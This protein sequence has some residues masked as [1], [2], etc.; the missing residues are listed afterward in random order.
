MLRR[1]GI[2]GSRNDRDMFHKI[3]WAKDWSQQSFFQFLCNMP[4]NHG[5][6]RDTAVS[7]ESLDNELSVW[8][9][10][11]AASMEQNGFVYSQEARDLKLPTCSRV[12]I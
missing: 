5:F 11:A 1:Y 6:A 4:C 12:V 3:E 7:H 2:N 8:L 10:F 9:D